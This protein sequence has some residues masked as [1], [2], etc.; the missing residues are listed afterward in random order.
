MDFTH[1]THESIPPF[2][3]EDSKILILGSLPSI[4]SR[5]DGFFYAH[6]QNRFFRTIANVFNEQEPKTIPERKEF[7]KRHHIA[8]YDVIYECDICGSSD[9]SI[10]NVVPIKLKEL[11]KQY[12]NI[13]M[14]YTTGKK[15]KELYD[16]YLL[17]DVGVS[18]IALPSSSAANAT[19]TLDV[20]VEE[21]KRKLIGANLLQ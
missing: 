12:P 1:V 2:I 21:Y 5:E 3:N 14:I 19:M 7:L 13:S 11:L 20:L 6:P 15:A 8:L 17:P 9:S 18:A 16:K 10:K 4:K